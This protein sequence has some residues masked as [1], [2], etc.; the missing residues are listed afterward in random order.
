LVVT[1]TRALALRSTN[2]LGPVV[3]HRATKTW[4]R[5]TDPLLGGSWWQKKGIR[6]MDSITKAIL[7][8][9]YPLLKNLASFLVGKSSI[10]GELSDLAK[11]D[12]R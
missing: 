6:A 11:F 10:N 3:P 4:G 5:K 8:Y 9:H 7:H 12:Y 2:C 1:T